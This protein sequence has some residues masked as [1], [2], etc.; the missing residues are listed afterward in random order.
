M[1]TGN[2]W[3][4]VLIVA[5]A[6][7]YPSWP[8]GIYAS[9]E[10]LLGGR[11][12]SSSGEALAGI[13]VR[14]RRENSTMT[15]SVYTNN[16]GEYSYPGWLGLSSGSYSVAIEL[17]DFEPVRRET[18]TLSSG[19]TARV[20]FT[21]QSRKPSLSDATAAE[22]MEALPGTD[23][24]K[25]LLI[26]CDNCHSL[27]WALKSPRTKEGWVQIVRKMMG[28]R[29][30]SSDNPGSRDFGQKRYIEPLADYLATIRGPG[31]SDQI[32]FQLRPR[33][34]SEASTRLVVT[35]YDIPRAGTWDVYRIRGD[36]KA[37]WPHDVAVDLKGPFVWYT[38]NF[39]NAIGR[40]NRNTGE[41]K[42][43]TYDLLSGMGRGAEMLKGTA[44]EQDRLGNPGGG[45][46]VIVSDPDGNLV[47]GVGSG[48][49]KF[50]R[51]TEKF[52]VWPSGASFLAMDP[53]GKVWYLDKGELR[54]LDL[55]S[56]ETKPY[57]VPSD[58]DASTYGI[59]VDSR[60]RSIFNLFR[61]G[62]IGMF[63]PKTGTYR[64]YPT[65]TPQSGPRRGEIDAKD[66]LWVG[67]YWAGRIARFDPST[68][69]VKEFSL[70]PDTKPFGAPF[71]A[72]YAVSADDRNQ[73]VWTHD[74][75][76][77]RLYSFDM[78]TEKTT[79]Y[80]TPSPY[81]VRHLAVDK[82]AKR[83]TVWIPVYRPPSKIVK[84]EVR[85]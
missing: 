71:P 64:E 65:P 58:T 17:A 30:A 34:T 52:S 54:K 23:E 32:P 78:R 8:T 9:E 24:Q 50:D 27:Q 80:L 16:R 53:D 76:S 1:N 83:P 29:R 35:E 28:E 42:E 56:G 12:T 22:I 31:S 66:R 51:S 37:V 45:A 47:I 26:Q 57:P 85:S 19:E 21:L 36:R 81:E 72:P 4:L 39:S 11:V 13:P 3:A 46:D 14:A 61:K 49:V 55:K 48:T 40:L 18:V 10:S 15:V 68:S 38:D 25:H 44:P 75:N 6:L 33:P 2:T 67:L 70:I 77:R 63:D 73:L 59:E 84:V 69:E 82:S 43:F 41:V 5:L 74:F 60:G 7:A 62:K 20:D 79:E